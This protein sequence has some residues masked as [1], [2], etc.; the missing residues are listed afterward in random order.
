MSKFIPIDKMK[1]LRE[2]VVSGDERAI[3]ILKAFRKG[4]DFSS[5]LDEYFSPKQEEVAPIQENV[6]EPAQKDNILDKIEEAGEEAT[7]KVL[8]D[9]AVETSECDKNNSLI[10]FIKSLIED[11]NEAI[12]GYDKTILY[13]AN[14]E[15]D[16]NALH[17]LEEIKNDE[18]RHIK[19]LKELLS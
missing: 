17:V 1:T 7:N 6:Q 2:A 10:E 19:M 5:L 3:N 12:E 9:V 8:S 11:E 15:I 14:S 13:V 16:R 18:I 4:E